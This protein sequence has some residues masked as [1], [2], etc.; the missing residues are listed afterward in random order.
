MHAHAH[1]LLHVNDFCPWR[2]SIVVSLLHALTHFLFLVFPSRR[3]HLPLN[4]LHLRLSPGLS[5]KR[6]RWKRRHGIGRHSTKETLIDKRRRS[7]AWTVSERWAGR[8]RMM[9][10]SPSVRQSVPGLLCSRQGVYN[11]RFIFTSDS[12]FLS[13]PKSLF[14]PPRSRRNYPAAGWDHRS[15]L[16]QNPKS[17]D[18]ILKLSHSQISSPAPWNVLKKREKCFGSYRRENICIFSQVFNTQDEI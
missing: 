1:Q 14:F 17:T 8:R 9:L 7:S 16:Q 4:L 6:S 3:H 2:R 12:N 11:I 18:V 13:P 5:I 10:V 15:R